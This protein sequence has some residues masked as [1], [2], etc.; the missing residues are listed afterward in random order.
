MPHFVLLVEAK[1]FSPF[2]MEVDV[3]D[4]EE[5]IDA[6]EKR[7]GLPVQ[8]VLYYDLDFQEYLPLEEIEELPL[9]GKAKVSLAVL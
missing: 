1:G 9:S 5:L 4:F 6:L 3:N 8:Q 2:R 7:I